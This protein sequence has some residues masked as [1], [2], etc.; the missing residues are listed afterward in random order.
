MGLPDT[1]DVD[2]GDLFGH[3][4]RTTED[5]SSIFKQEFETMFGQMGSFIVKKQ[6]DDLTKGE[7]ISPDRLP[8]IINKLSES[9]IS[10]MGP[11]AAKDLKRNLRRRCGLP[12]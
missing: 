7:D 3:S 11:K 1:S 8:F 10:V 9:V 12:V 5:Y 6:L 4:S 2:V